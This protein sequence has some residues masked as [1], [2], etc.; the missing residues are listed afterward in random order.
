VFSVIDGRHRLIKATREGIHELRCDVISANGHA[1]RI[2]PTQE[3][4][5]DADV[6]LDW[7]FSERRIRAMGEWDER[8]AGVLTVTPNGDLS[9]VEKSIIKN[10]LDRERRHVSALE[11]LLIDIGR[12]DPDAVAIQQDAEA[13]GFKI[14]R[15]SKKGPFYLL[16]CASEL[17]KLHRALGSEKMRQVHALNTHFRGERG[18]NTG[19]WLGGL[20][21]LARDGYIDKMTPASFAALEDVVPAVELRRAK[22]RGIHGSGNVSGFSETS[23]EI[24]IALRKKM[25]LKVMPAQKN[26]SRD[27][28]SRPLS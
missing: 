5:V 1:L 6:Q 17:R 21:L 25:R 24:A 28:H 26:S 9:V 14:G 16:G 23:Y 3:L 4:E 8:K 11:G 12:G 27:S 18:T 22:G 15:A 20:G 7:A 10:G 13:Y 19:D 2:I